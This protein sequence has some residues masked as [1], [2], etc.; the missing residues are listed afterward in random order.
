MRALLGLGLLT[1]PGA[2][3]AADVAGELRRFHTVTL[4]FAGPQASESDEPS[5]FAAYELSAIV[6][7]PET[8]QRHTV[9]GFFA[10]DGNAA[11]SSAEAGDRWRIRFSPPLAGT[12]RYEARLTRDGESV[13]LDAASGEFAV[14]ETELGTSRDFRTRGHLQYVGTRYYELSGT[15]QPFLK[16]G[17][18]SPETLL[19]YRE[20]DGTRH[21]TAE[22]P[23]PAP[24]D[25][26]R[27]PALTDGLHQYA[28]HIRDW[29]EGDPTWYG[30][31]GKGLVGA[32][33]YLADAGANSTYF[34]TMNVNGDGR[35]VWP[36]T[37]PWEHDRF[38]VS[39]LAQWDRVFSHMQ[40]RGVAMHVVLQETEND[41]LLDNGEL[42]PTR[43]LYL[44]EM[45]ARFGHHPAVI[46]NLGEENLQTPAQQRAMA[47]YLREL[48]P[49]GHP[50]VVHNDHHTEQD[51]AAT[52]DPL[53][54]TAALDGTSIQDFHWADVHA[55]TRH[56]INASAAAGKPWVVCV[57]EMGG[58]DR[59][60]P[61]DD[62]EP[63][64]FHARAYGL[65][66]NLMAG[67][68]GV[69]WYFGWQNNSPHS[70]LSAESWRPRESMWRQ[71]RIAVDVLRTLPLRRMASR[72]DL[73]TAA[74]D[75][76]L[77]EPGQ[78]YAIY[79]PHGQPTRLDLEDGD[80]TFSVRWFDPRD[81]GE[82]QTGSVAVV[83]G[84]GQVGTGKPPADDGRDW[85]CL[86][87][88]IEPVFAARDD[89]AIVVEAERFR[90]VDE[91]SHAV[92]TWHTLRK[93]GPVPDLLGAGKATTWT[94][95]ILAAAKPA[96]GGAFIRI[97]PDTRRSHDDR[98]IRGE[99]FSPEPGQM[100]IIGYPVR[101]DEPGR[102]FVWVRAFS[103]NSEDNGLHVGV[104][105]DWP[106]HGRRM[107]WC[108]G[109]H[110]WTWGCAQRTEANHCGEPMQ[111]WLE[112]EAGDHEIQFSMREDGFAFDQ[113]LLTRDRNDR[114]R[115][116]ERGERIVD[117]GLPE[118]TPA[119]SVETA[120]RFPGE[121]WVRDTPGSQGIDAE[122][123]AEALEY[124]RG[125]CQED[126]LSELI[127]A[128]RGVIIHEG[129]NTTRRHN[130]W[131]CTKSFTSTALGLLIGD[132]KCSLDDR[133]AD[134]ETL[135]KQGYA[136]A[137]LRHFATMTSGYNA[138]GDSRWTGDNADWSHTPYVPGEPLFAP[139]EAY[140]YWDEAMIM[141]G[142]VLTRIAGQ[143]LHEMLR[144]RIFDPIGV[145]P[146][147]WWAEGKATGVPI[148]VGGTGLE[149]TARDAARFA[150]L[151]LNEG[152]WDGEPLV[153]ADWV[154]QATRNQVP[155]EL[156]TGSSDRD[157]THGSGGYGFNWWTNGGA[158]RMPDAPPRTYYASGL[159]HN[160]IFVVPEW[161]MVIVRLGT[162]GNPPMGK[163]AAWNG[164]FRRL[165]KG[166]R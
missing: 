163:A 86:V 59:G 18:G 112:L 89:G 124:L 13:P 131:S 119:E 2:L 162:D 136:E 111:I 69:D 154:R 101:I 62:D 45:V 36:W 54:G 114:P 74:D 78:T 105:G 157:D 127:V 93:S 46:W 42:G 164:F 150:H 22:H 77:A 11:E 50:I 145:G 152:Q 155:P 103:S 144:E 20:F 137:T 72:D 27:L 73:T 3:S 31:H 39:K 83:R 147:K 23:I 109:K 56:Y 159:N 57:D 100:A 71:S 87:R 82:L 104:D 64:H 91:S 166:V 140:A 6:W 88:R 130:L 117:G 7:H 17:A 53:L 120:M 16:I 81:G 55:H 134:Y 66:G 98:L 141:N 24:H 128:R 160:L 1:I 102:Y 47:A 79:L 51:I 149:M 25:P 142:R 90:R 126:G 118:E 110:Q 99:N 151:F 49:Y 94:R 95:G 148:C 67:G 21:D 33:N 70:D 138:V 68:G 15:R 37:G 106:E 32:I 123:L 60:L 125:H 107:Q 44:R 41:H 80:A 10:A 63:D 135:L 84:P 153:P 5:P 108:E 133:A 28:D 43:R 122:A 139:G 158:V 52:F 146:T 97:L 156:P 76:C 61:T 115:G 38:D 165:A 34:V 132:G 29:R 12:W 19:G 161:E 92:R 65:W 75:Y 14:E 129:E 121:T 48:D 85:V 26:I 30:D 4:T 143:S 8:S 96:G 9:P 40:A 35:N 58:A 116:A 113:F